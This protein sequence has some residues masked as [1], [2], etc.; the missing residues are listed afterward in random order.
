MAAKKKAK[1]KIRAK[2]LA[3]D[4]AAAKKAKGEPNPRVG[5]K[6]TPFRMRR[7]FR[8]H[9]DLS[10][11]RIWDWYATGYFTQAELAERFKMSVGQVGAMCRCMP[12]N[13]GK[14]KR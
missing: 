4:L 5:V 3:S 14:R 13:W 11:R 9:D 8:D 10:V 2:P 12:A 6:E 1:K 7:S